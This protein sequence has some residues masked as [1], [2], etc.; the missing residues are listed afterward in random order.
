[1]TQAL[2]NV[3]LLLRGDIMENE[4][5]FNDV[6]YRLMSNGKYYLSQSTTNS[7]RKKAKG[8][9]VA[10][11]EYYND[12]TVPIGCEIHH[13]DGNTLN[14][15]I[16]NLECLT[17]KQHAKTKNYAKQPEHLSRIRKLSK[18][19][20]SSE[21][22]IKWH[23]EH[24]KDS[25][26]KRTKI[27]LVCKM[28]GKEF[29]TVVHNARFCSHN[30][31]VKWDYRAKTKEIFKNCVVCG[32]EFTAKITTRHKE[33]KITCSKSCASKLLHKNLKKVNK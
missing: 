24:A 29:E 7:G 5:I 33:G 3:I 19:W 13:T 16:E 6:I 21:E 4:I 11:W 30:C 28:C 18:E 17:T 8:L 14:N 31:S 2:K 12:K 26:F 10:I 23:R 32:K 25:I 1:M 15:S 22:G 9:H 20:H 27:T